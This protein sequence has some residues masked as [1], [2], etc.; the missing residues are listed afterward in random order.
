[1]KKLIIISAAALLLTACGGGKTTS[2]ETTAKRDTLVYSQSSDAVTLNPHMATDLYSRRVLANIFDRLVETDEELNL[3]PGL[4]KSW[5]QVDETT[6]VFNLR[7]GV[8]F[9]NGEELTSEDVKYTLEKA[10]ESPAVGVLYK[11]IKEVETP[12]THTVVVKSYEA[13]GSLIHHLSHIT[14]SIMN[15]KHNESAE[16]IAIEPVGTGAYSLSQ[17]NPGDRM[18]LV[19]NEDYFRGVA[20]IENI[21]IR[22]I[23][24]ETSRVIGLETGE[25]HISTDIETIARETIIEHKEINLEEM[26]SLGVAYMGLNAGSGPTSDKRVRQAI[27]YAIDK[28]A[29]INSVLMGS[30][31][32]ANTLL[33]PGVVG[34]STGTKEIGYDVE[35]AKALIDEAGYADGLNLRLVTSNNELRRQMSE[36]IQAQLKEIG[37]ELSI[38]ILEWST[39]LSI[40]GNGEAD[41]FMLGWSNSSGDADYGMTP[42]LHGSMVGSGGNRS[43][44]ENSVFDEL[45]ELG[46]GE[47]DY[48]TRMDYYAQAQDVMNEEVPIYP[49]YFMLANAGIRKEVEG[50]VQT[51][52]NN[53]NFFKLSFQ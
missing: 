49:L 15:K 35:K 3:V 17:W 18:S 16:N 28:D 6:L 29:I 11:A 8:K 53:P 47:L 42:I 12:D 45:L 37:V 32:N 26:S 31:E 1:M 9:H 39:F 5:D 52:I 21:E 19:R 36:I 2:N 40:T 27:A 10:T 22:P 14:A 20:P 48:D 44:F 25:I 50:F 30:V 23:P 33:G 41:L 38:E 34:H 43:Y 51:P 13:S 46:S 4:A 24:E 7:E